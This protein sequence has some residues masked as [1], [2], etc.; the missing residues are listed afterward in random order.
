MRVTVLIFLV[1]QAIVW[2]H[3]FTANEPEDVEV[4]RQ[5]ISD[6]W[7]VIS[8]NDQNE[9]VVSPII[10]YEQLKLNL[11][12]T[13]SITYNDGNRK[14]GTWK[15]NRKKKILTLQSRE[16]QAD[17]EIVMLPN[18]QSNFLIIRSTIPKNK[19]G[20]EYMLTRL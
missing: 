10:N 3:I 15:I 7:E 11:D 17:F 19:K 2:S 1:I 14:A 13:F 8:I 12:G 20:L 6:T 18:K 9:N 5:M 16:D 4:D